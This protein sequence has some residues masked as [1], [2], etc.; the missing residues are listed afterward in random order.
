MVVPV[1]DFGEWTG[2]GQAA[3]LLYL[4][5][6]TEQGVGATSGTGNFWPA[7]FFETHFL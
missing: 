4:G 7:G 1:G 2:I 5:E 3:C 6:I